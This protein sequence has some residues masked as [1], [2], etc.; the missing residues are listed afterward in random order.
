MIDVPSRTR[1][2]AGLV[3]V[4]LISAAPVRAQA[5]QPDPLLDRLI[6]TWVLRGTIAGQETVHDMTCR[7]VLGAEYVEIHEVS[8][9]KT[10]SGTPA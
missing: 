5:S 6:G 2:F 10:P 7:W 1:R 9:E 3:F 4:T 8:R